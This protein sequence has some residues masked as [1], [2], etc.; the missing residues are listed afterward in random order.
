M[1][2]AVHLLVDKFDILLQN[3]LK[4]VLAK[5][6][7]DEVDQRMRTLRQ[8]SQAKVLCSKCKS[9]QAS[10]T[11]KPK[12]CST[13]LTDLKIKSPTVK[14]IRTKVR[15]RVDRSIE[16]HHQ[17]LQSPR[18]RGTNGN[19]YPYKS[20]NRWFESQE[21]SIRSVEDLQYSI[22]TSP[23]NTR[24][25]SPNRHKIHAPIADAS[26]CSSDKVRAYGHG[27]AHLGHHFPPC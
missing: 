11:S 7:K 12:N 25:R 3:R 21:S 18:T 6:I 17:R 9:A 23:A 15:E 1:K 20:P 26:F 10:T 4:L 22:E 8:L 27:P 5:Q 24:T 13:C 19:K 2:K 16:H 14:Q